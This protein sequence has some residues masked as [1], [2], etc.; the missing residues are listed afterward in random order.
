MKRIKFALVA[1]ALVA[2][3]VSTFAFT[4]DKAQ[5]PS[6]LKYYYFIGDNAIS[7]LSVSDLEDADLWVVSSTAP[8]TSSGNFLDAIVFMQETTPNEDAAIT[9]AQAIAA[10]AAHYQGTPT[11]EFDS[12]SFN[13]TGDATPTTV[14]L[15][16]KT[17]S[18]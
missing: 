6:A 8:V 12:Y 10:V 15:Y 17:S 11:F 1:L 3:L 9:K 18:N 5:K 7:S 2:G 14:T 16:K 13:L 4:S